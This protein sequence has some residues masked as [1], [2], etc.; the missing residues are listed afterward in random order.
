MSGTS[1]SSSNKVTNII[2]KCDYPIPFLSLSA[3]SQF[4]Y[5]IQDVV[6]SNTRA[7]LVYRL[8]YP[9]LD[10]PTMPKRELFDVFV[11]RYTVFFS[12]PFVQLFRR[13]HFRHSDA[14]QK[15]FC[16]LQCAH[17]RCMLLIFFAPHIGCV[18]FALLF[19]HHHASI[20][21]INAFMA[22]TKYI[23]ISE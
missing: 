23:Y 20:R 11:I 9:E 2:I 15:L 4:R 6:Q 12:S 10:V 19:I 16:Q 8:G 1:S 13:N 14:H 7:L 22:C 18:V 5:D 3:P 21:W 17:C